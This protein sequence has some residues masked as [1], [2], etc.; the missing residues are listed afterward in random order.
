MAKYFLAESRD[1]QDFCCL[2]TF[3]PQQCCKMSLEID[4]MA[5]SKAV[6]FVG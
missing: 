5:L 2:N 3:Y 6:G 4:L 1:L